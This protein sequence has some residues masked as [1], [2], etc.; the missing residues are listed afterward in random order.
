MIDAHNGNKIVS[1]DE[2]SKNSSLD[3]VSA[4]ELMVKVRE[5]C[6]NVGVSLGETIDIEDNSEIRN[7]YNRARYDVMIKDLSRYPQMSSPNF[8]W[9]EIDGEPSP[10][11]SIAA[12]QKMCIGQEIFSRCHQAR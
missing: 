11:Q 1:E 9:E 10:T 8:M 3:V 4:N 5:E 7:G 12:L 2:R 6:K